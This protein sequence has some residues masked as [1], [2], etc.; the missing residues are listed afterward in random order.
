MAETPG[1][2]IAVRISHDE[3]EGFLSLPMPAPGEQYEFAEVMDKIE[4]KGL[5]FGVYEDTI[6]EMINH[7]QYNVERLVAKG[8]P[9]TDGID[10]FFQ[11][12]FNA[13]FNTKPTVRADG[14]VDYWSIHVVEIVEE[15]QVIAVY[16]EPISGE[17]GTTVGGKVLLAKRGRPLPPMTGKGF[18]R[19]EDGKVY[20]AS[21]TG[22][23]DKNGNR[24]QILPVYEVYGNV[25]LSTGNIDF[26]GDV[27]IHGNVTTG[28]SIKATGTVTVDGIVEAASIEADRDIILRGGVLGKGKAVIKTK[29]NI[30]AKFLEYAKVE[31]EGFLEA[32]SALDCY[33]NVH[34]KVIMNSPS[35][36]I[37]GGKVYAAKGIEVYTCG[38][39]SEVS[40][41]L[42]VGMDKVMAARAVEIH[43]QLS[44]QNMMLDKVNQGLAHFDEL[45]K[46]KGVDISKDDR[47]VSLLRARIATQAEIAKLNEELN[48]INEIIEGAKGATIMVMSTV[49]SGVSATIDNITAHV[50]AKQY[51]VQ[52]IVRDGNVIMVPVEY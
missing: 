44:D 15:G 2:D 8:V 49:Y 37:V 36:A 1:R 45:A 10:G 14:T 31:A 17:N 13:E 28:S 32:S 24:I 39:D 4:K 27:I 34:D 47:R 29:G 41:E 48:Y 5:R 22:K 7:E 21:L 33:I 20:V 18:T 16:H 11:L 26:K 3:M 46:E 43:K 38:N 35:S 50:K 9:M 25:D 52:F 30:T 23:I 6:R 19:S 51:S 40:T 42:Q 12:N